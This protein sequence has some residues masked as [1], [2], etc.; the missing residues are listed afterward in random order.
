MSYVQGTKVKVW[1]EF[2]DGETGVAEDP[3]SVVLTIEMPDGTTEE[4]TLVGG[5]VIND[6]SAVGRFYSIV[7]TTP[8]WGNWTY[9]FESEGPEAVVA[10]RQFTVKRRLVAA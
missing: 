5:G 9:Q 10:K 6:P 3:A 2:A 4:R 8:Q 1:A 7:D